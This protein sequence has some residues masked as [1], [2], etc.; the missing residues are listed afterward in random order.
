[1]K[2]REFIRLVGGA[3]ATWPLAALAQNTNNAPKRIAF[4]PDPVPSVLEG[5]RADM[6]VLGWIEKQDFFVLPSGIEYG[7][8]NPSNEDAQRVVANKPDLIFTVSTNYALAAQ[9]ATGSIPIVMLTSG[10]PVEAGVADSLARP[11]RN[12]TGNT[13]YAETGVWGKL[14]QLL[15]E[16]KP[17]IKRVGILWT[18]V[19]PAFPKEEIEPGYT[20]LNSAA[21]WLNLELHIVEVA[22]SD[23][24]QAA[25][26]ELRE[27]SPEGLLLT[28]FFAL[29][30]RSVVTQ[31]ALDKGLPTIADADWTRVAPPHPLL[32]YGP[33]S[34]ELIQNAVASVDK[35]LRGASPGDL[36]I[37]RPSRFELVVSLTTAKA[38]GLDLP[39][40]FLA[41]AD[42][43]IE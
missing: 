18:Y 12:V 38:I 34:R 3:T 41:Q 13:A 23:Q 31:F 35:I 28:S 27:R 4:F 19:T 21:R 11:G 15:R 42:R 33:I 24:V 8:R 36:P 43:V 1:M 17:D 6:R 26:A 30:A 9:R 22:N 25:L 39:P 5:W 37:Q 10:Y 32:C 16:A 2:R 14:L 7:S 29:K 40:V 20:E